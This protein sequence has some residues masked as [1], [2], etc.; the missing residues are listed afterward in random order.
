MTGTRLYGGVG[1]RNRAYRPPSTAASTALRPSRTELIYRDVVIPINF[2]D[3]TSEN[4]T[5]F[6]F[7]ATA[8][9][10]EAYVNV[11]TAE[12]TGTTKTLQ[13]GTATADGGTPNILLDGLS[14]SSTGLLNYTSC[15]PVAIT[16]GSSPATYTTPYPAEVTVTGGTTTHINI[17][18]NGVTTADLATTTPYSI[19]L[20]NGDAVNV[21]YS[22]TPTVKAF[23]AGGMTTVAVGGKRISWTPA[24]SDWANFDGDLIV[25][26][27]VMGDLTKSSENAGTGPEQG[28][29]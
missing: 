13:V 15:G 6:K 11:R 5:N 3:G 16:L 7:P 29:D 18:R 19:S 12:A 28:I 1:V 27:A 23:Q 17:T 8:V 2:A 4:P 10:Y 14:V 21:T 22:V 20:M 25:R 26:Y 9:A 24:S